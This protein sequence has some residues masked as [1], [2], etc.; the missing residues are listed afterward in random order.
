M[1]KK[2]DGAAYS[3]ETGKTISVQQLLDELN[4]IEDKSRPVVMLNTNNMR[5]RPF[6]GI[7][8]WSE[9]E[10]DPDDIWPVHLVI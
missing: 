9:V 8:I 6:E 1:F 3:P 5:A 7:D 2:I 4:G 10:A